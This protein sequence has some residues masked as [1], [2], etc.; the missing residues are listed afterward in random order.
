MKR[1]FAAA[2][3]LALTASAAAAQELNIYNWGN[4]T[5]P[6]LIEKFE[7]ET[8]IKAHEQPQN[9][10]PLLDKLFVSLIKVDVT[11]GIVSS[12]IS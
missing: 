11:S 1:L 5:N 12:P 8:G 10:S 2:S 4:Y 6:K 3:V 7:E 9:H